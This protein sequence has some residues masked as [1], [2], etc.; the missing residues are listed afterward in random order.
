MQRAPG[1]YDDLARLSRAQVG[2][3]GCRGPPASR[4]QHRTTAR[5]SCRMESAVRGAWA[6]SAAI[7]HAP[8]SSRSEPPRSGARAGESGV[9]LRPAKSARNGI[10][11]CRDRGTK[12][13]TRDQRHRRDPRGPEP[14]A[15]IP[16]ER[17]LFEPDG[18]PPGSEGLD[19]GVRSQIRTGLRLQFPANREINRE[20]C[21]FGAFGS[22]ISTKNPCA[23]AVS[24]Q[25]PCE[26]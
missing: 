8:N 14:I 6:E 4:H 13:V 22:N 12:I 25:F 24:R 26:N 19:G 3:C 18:V 23:A 15:E 2:S 1:Q 16:E 10:F 7:V 5:C 21:D 11:G 9:V 17:G 20:L